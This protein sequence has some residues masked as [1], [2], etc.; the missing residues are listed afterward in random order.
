[1]KF[2][3]NLR[4]QK[5]IEWFSDLLENPGGPTWLERL[6]KWRKY[7]NI[8]ENTEINWFRMKDT[9][10]IGA[11]VNKS[12]SVV[13]G[14]LNVY[15]DYGSSEARMSTGR[16]RITTKREDRAMVKLVKKDRF[17]TAAAVSRE[18][19]VQLGKP[20]SRKTVSRRLVEQQLLAR[21][22]VVKPLISSKNKKCHLAFANDDVLWSQEKW[23]T[24]DF[25]DESKFLLIGSDGKMYVRRKALR[26]VLNSVEE[27]SWF[28]GWYLEMVWALWCD[29]K[30][31]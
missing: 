16:P 23:L 21:E 3:C 13:H 5:S 9:L 25:S 31:R 19:S 2:W 11:I 4:W 8:T 12:K 17:K 10:S 6:K 15:N 22:P 29:Y 7:S 1:M 20:L 30:E 27:V 26:L 14:F 18:M 28:E 24:L